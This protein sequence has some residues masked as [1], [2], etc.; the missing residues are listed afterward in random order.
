MSKQGTGNDSLAQVI[1]NREQYGKT[2]RLLESMQNDFD[3]ETLYKEV[4]KYQELRAQRDPLAIKSKPKQSIVKFSSED[5]AYRSRIT[6]IKLQCRQVLFRV[7]WLLES[8]RSWVFSTFSSRMEG[9]VAVKNSYVETIVSDVSE[10]LSQLQALDDC[11]DLCLNDIDQC[12]W[13]RKA[14]VS[15]LEIQARPEAKL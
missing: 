1:R 8:F 4:I 7:E 3:L 13:Q 6:Y 10:Y 12:Q 9:S 5:N 2:M 11:C 14:A 15:V